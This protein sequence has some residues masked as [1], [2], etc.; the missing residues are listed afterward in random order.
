MYWVHGSSMV[1]DRGGEGALQDNTGGSISTDWKKPK[2]CYNVTNFLVPCVKNG[3]S[4]N[5]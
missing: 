2:S 1:A 4:H 3:D 5:E